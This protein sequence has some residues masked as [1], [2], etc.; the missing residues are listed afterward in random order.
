MKFTGFL[1][2]SGLLV[3]SLS[4]ASIAKEGQVYTWRDSNGVVHYGERPPKDVQAKPVKTRTGHSDP[5]PSQTAPA[6]Q[7]QSATTPPQDASSTKLLDPNRCA[8]AQA[9][10]KLLNTVARIKMPD[11]NG[12][13]A[14][15]TE[16]DKAKQR[17][18]MQAVIDQACE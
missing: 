11:E 16:E 5:T 14:F 4:V 9:N 8:Q 12:N 3:A 15:L 7:Q 18:V 2:A 13:M 10:L 17:E 6:T 1:L